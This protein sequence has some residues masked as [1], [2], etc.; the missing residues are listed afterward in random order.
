MKHSL[1]RITRAHYRVAALRESSTATMSGIDLN[2]YWMP[3]TD[4]VEFKKNPKKIFDRAEGVHYFLE[5]GTP[6]LDSISG[7][8]YEN[9]SYCYRK[10]NLSC[11]AVA[12]H[13]IFFVLFAGVSTQAMLN[14]R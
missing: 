6:I 4:N 3:F 1:T 7:L 12:N 8:W 10:L 2:G 14:R 9:V 5:D 11:E 13:S